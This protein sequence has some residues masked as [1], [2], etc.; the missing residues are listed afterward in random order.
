MRFEFPAAPARQG[1]LPKLRD[2]LDPAWESRY[3]LS[4]HLWSYLQEYRRKHRAA[5]NGFG[6]GLF[7]GDE[8][9]WNLIRRK[10]H[11]A[12]LRR[13]F[14]ERKS[15]VFGIYWDTPDLAGRIASISDKPRQWRKQGD[16]HDL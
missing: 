9:P 2:I 3:V 8:E 10:S 12:V 6:Y 7:G 5:G 16:Q 11:A 4:D 15:S 1:P 13:Y 14:D